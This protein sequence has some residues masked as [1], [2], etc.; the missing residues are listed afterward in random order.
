[1]TR[2]YV[3]IGSN[4]DRDRNIRAGIAALEKQ[5]G[6]LILSSV[7]ESH[8]YGFEGGNFYN[9]VAGFDTADTI[10]Q[11]ADNLRKI[12][13]SFGRK[14]NEQRFKSRTLDLD[15]LLY[16]DQIRHDDLHVPRKDITQYAFVLCPLAEIAGNS[17]HPE[18]G[19]TY[20][21]LWQSFSQDD[22]PVWVVDFELP[23]G[24]HAR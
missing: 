18:Q 10:E 3:G 14:R 7:Y 13:F 12:E 11:V 6:P 8:A 9:L 17:R 1:M 23:V 24:E 19:D 22:Q 4:I 2:V 16:G 15:L 5:Y 20:Y 21:D